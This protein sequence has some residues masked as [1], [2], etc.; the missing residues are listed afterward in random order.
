MGDDG[1]ALKR[2]KP[3]VDAAEQRWL[4]F[5][6]HELIDRP[7]CMIVAPREGM[8]PTPAP[9]YMAGAHG[10]FD[11]VVEQALAWGRSTYWAGDAIPCYTPSFGPD[12]FASWL[13]AEL[14]FPEDGHGT[15]WALPCVDDWEGALPLALDPAN[16]WWRRMFDFCRAL[17]DGFAGEMLVTHVDMHSNM[18]AL[19]A[20]RGGM[21]LC[22]D[23]VETPE[24]IDRAAVGVRSLYQPIDRALREAGRMTR[25]SAW[26]PVYHP[27]RTNTIQCDFAALIGPRHFR[28]WALP[29]LAEEAAYLGRCIMHYD[30]PE[31]LVHLD[32][33]C[34]IEGLECIQ[35]QPGAGN[36]PFIEWMDLLQEIQSRGVAVYVPCQ[37]D[38]IPVYHRALRPELVCYHCT[39]RSQQEADDALRWLEAHT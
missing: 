7:C 26:L 20:L 19:L 17:A 24:L 21:R 33:I 2:L 15:S 13:G 34:A 30:G 27:Q 29:A 39:A 4:A 18:D 22:M 11:P 28:R 37:A 31:M 1:D 6:Q 12:M 3:D 23:L 8:D 35:W 10:D 36:R 32:D 9:P 16:P 25:A 5:W 38:A 14:V